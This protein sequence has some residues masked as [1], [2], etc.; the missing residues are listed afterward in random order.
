MALGLLNKSQ[1]A[2]LK[3]FDV[4]L[5]IFLVKEICISILKNVCKLNFLFQTRLLK[6]TL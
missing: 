4:L 5:E 6:D 3:R 2:S 1:A